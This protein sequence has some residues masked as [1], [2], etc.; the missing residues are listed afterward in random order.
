[1]TRAITHKDEQKR[2]LLYIIGDL[3][4]SIVSWVIYFFFKAN[5]LQ[6]ATLSLNTKFWVTLT[7]YCCGWMFL[8]YLSGYYNRPIPKSRVSELFTTTITTFIGCVI[9]FFTLVS[10]D[11]VEMEDVNISIIALF[12][13]QFTLTYIIRL[14]QTQKI[15][16]KIHRREIGLNTVI[17]GD[18]KQAEL[19]K[20]RWEKERYSSGYRICHEKLMPWDSIGI[21]PLFAET[22]KGQECL[23]DAII[24]FIR[25]ENIP[26]NRYK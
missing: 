21:N 25:K 14:I 9:L 7:A 15:N 8:H 20:A 16:D 12:S 22:E 18:K 26:S 19:L 17:I 1:M 4:A 5:V 10:N 6:I 11:E 3:T 2:R 24:D 13:I 23:P